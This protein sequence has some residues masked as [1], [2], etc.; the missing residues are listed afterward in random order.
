V[1]D[2]LRIKINSHYG[3]KRYENDNYIEGNPW[4]V[5]T[6]WLSKTMLALASALQ[7]EGENEERVQQL[8]K[9]AT[10]YIKWALGG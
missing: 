3:I 5:T 9:D 6:L 1:E 7:C 8:V 4:I 2:T 10:N